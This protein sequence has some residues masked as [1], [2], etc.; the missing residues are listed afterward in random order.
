VL[1]ENVVIQFDLGDRDVRRSAI[2]SVGLVYRIFAQVLSWL[3][4]FGRSSRRRTRRY[5]HWQTIR[6]AANRVGLRGRQGVDERGEHRA[7][8]I[9]RRGL[10]LVVQK[11]GRVDTARGGHFDVSF[12]S[13]VRG[14]PKDHAVAA[15]HVCATPI[16][17]AGKYTTLPDATKTSARR[18]DAQILD[19]CMT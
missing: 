17:R 1:A 10:Q 16:N 13:T 8:Q 18:T 5:S 12:R 9:R 15:L 19:R 7:Q 3:V 11:A 14:L 6:N 4:L 2:V